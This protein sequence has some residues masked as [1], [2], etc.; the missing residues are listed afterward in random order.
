MTS[1]AKMDDG[2][3]TIII[4]IA[5]V[6]CRDDVGIPSLAYLSTL[7]VNFG[8]EYNSNQLPTYSSIQPELLSL[9][10]FLTNV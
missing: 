3:W 10:H 6:A 8:Q 2:R 5:K 4:P 9:N 7:T 1:A